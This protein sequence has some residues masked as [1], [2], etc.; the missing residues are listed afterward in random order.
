VDPGD[1][2]PPGGLTIA[3]G[4]PIL[5]N[6]GG[7]PTSQRPHDAT[8]VSTVADSMVPKQSDVQEMVYS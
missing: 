3:A 5:S 7:A 6:K 8:I 2:F 1:V 4:A